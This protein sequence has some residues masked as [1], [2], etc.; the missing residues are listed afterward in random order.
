[1]AVIFAS[2]SVT[3]LKFFIKSSNEN[4]YNFCNSSS[5]VRRKAA[6]LSSSSFS[7]INS[8]FETYE[9]C[10]VSEKAD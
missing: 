4:F 3:N 9:M 5:N 8:T 6:V 10:S 7:L 2:Q 1:M